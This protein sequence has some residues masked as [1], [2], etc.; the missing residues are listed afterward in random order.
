AISKVAKQGGR[1]DKFFCSHTKWA[2]LAK[3]M[4]AQKQYIS[5]GR[6]EVGTANFETLQ[7]AS[8]TGV[9]D[10]IADWA[11]P[12]SNGYLLEMD[13]WTLYSVDDVP[14]LFNDDQRV[15]RVVGT[16]GYEVRAGLYAQ[17]GC[18]APGA[19]AVVNF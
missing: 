4:Q 11:C 14:H 10:V 1:P 6:V 17:L 12:D 5:Q 13:T 16:D 8:S 15:I 19:N 7:I 18:S 3:N 9:I 2:E